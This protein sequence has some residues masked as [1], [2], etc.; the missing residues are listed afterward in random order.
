[1]EDPPGEFSIQNK[2]GTQTPLVRYE[3]SHADKTLGVYIAM[4]GYE[5]AEIKHLTRCQ[6]N[7]GI[8]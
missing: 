4:D 7:S 8:S 1:M 6:K 3:A 5:D 2:D